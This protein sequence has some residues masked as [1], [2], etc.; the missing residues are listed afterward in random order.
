MVTGDSQGRRLL[1]GVL[2]DPETFVGT[3]EVVLSDSRVCR[4]GSQTVLVAPPWP[5]GEL[6]ATVESLLKSAVDPADQEDL[7][8]ALWMLLI[9]ED[10]I[11]ENDASLAAEY[12]LLL[13]GALAR[14]EVRP[15]R[16]DMV[17]G[18]TQREANRIR[19]KKPRA[20]KTEANR[21]SVV[22]WVAD[23]IAKGQKENNAFTRAKHRAKGELGLDLSISTI[24]RAFKGTN[25]PDA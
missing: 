10:A 23:A 18:E 11:A 6:K 8:H 5:P 17:L 4:V 3:Q 24:R 13:G 16:P 1:L 12:A 2:D 21:A 22:S 19:A 20:F 7:K 25:S 14:Y 9:I 15:K